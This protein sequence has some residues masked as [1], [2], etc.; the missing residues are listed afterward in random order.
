MT[1]RYA[2]R[3]YQWDD[4]QFEA[5]TELPRQVRVSQHRID[6]GAHRDRAGHFRRVLPADHQDEFRAVCCFGK[7]QWTALHTL[8][9]QS[10][11][12]VVV[13]L[14]FVDPLAIV[15]LRQHFLSCNPDA[16]LV[17]FK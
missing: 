16:G 9:D 13:K 11:F 8:S 1:S 17:K 15:R 4:R 12:N 14:Q 3:I 10:G 5:I 6:E 7:I 2:I